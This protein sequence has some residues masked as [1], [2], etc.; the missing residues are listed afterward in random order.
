MKNITVFDKRFDNFWL[1]GL[2][3]EVIGSKRDKLG[4]TILTVNDY[5]NN[6]NKRSNQELLKEYNK[7]GIILKNGFVGTQA[8]SITSLYE[9]ER[10]SYSYPNEY[11]DFGTTAIFYG[12]LRAIRDSLIKSAYN[13][14]SIINRD[15]VVKLIENEKESITIKFKNLTDE[16]ILEKM[17]EGTDKLA[18]KHGRKYGAYGSGVKY[19]F[20]EISEGIHSKLKN[21]TIMTV[22]STPKDEF[23][24]IEGM[25]VEDH[26]V[27]NLG[28]EV[29][30]GTVV[31]IREKKKVRYVKIIPVCH[32]C[33]TRYTKEQ[34]FDNITHKPGGYWDEKYK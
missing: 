3:V 20:D 23:K 2:D 1:T 14:A 6:L 10:L 12:S 4:N 25:C 28:K 9:Y 32:R 34:F 27:K 19:E 33:Q 29:K 15:R 7:N 24:N 16:E 13:E 21:G 31:G 26:L 17:N 30:I 18:L 5:G 8:S 22:H 11:T